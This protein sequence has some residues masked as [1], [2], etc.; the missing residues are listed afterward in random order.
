M[1]DGKCVGYEPAES[2]VRLKG[3]NSNWRGPIWFPTGFL[4]IESLRKLGTA[5]GTTLGVPARAGRRAAP[6][7][8]HD[9][10]REI[11]DRLIRIFT[12][13][14][15]GRRPVFGGS[16]TFQDDPALARP[17]P[18]LRI[19]PRRQRRRPRRLAPDRLDGPG[20][21]ADRRVA[22]VSGEPEDG[23]FEPPMNTDEY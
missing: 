23:E 8:F 22:A 13:D 16:E 9:L 7:P 19:L 15:T 3:G 6:I 10:A 14:A 11:A 17:D 4:L 5:F 1:F 21:L 2:T 20:R 12:R 18:L